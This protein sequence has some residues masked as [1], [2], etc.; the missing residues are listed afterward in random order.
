MQ[1]FIAEENDLAWMMLESISAGDKRIDVHLNMGE[2]ERQFPDNG[3]VRPLSFRIWSTGDDSELLQI[4]DFEIG[5]VQGVSATAAL[6]ETTASGHANYGILDVDASYQ[7]IR[8][9]ILK[10]VAP[11]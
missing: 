8:E 7:T 11:E 6:G 9:S 3:I 2:R 10:L 1:Q 4:I 5:R